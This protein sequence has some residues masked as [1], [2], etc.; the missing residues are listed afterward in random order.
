MAKYLISFPADAMQLTPGELRQ[1]SIDSHAVVAEA[2]PGSFNC[3]GRI[4]AIWRHLSECVIRSKYP[5]GIPR[6]SS[7]EMRSPSRPP[8]QPLN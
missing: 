3:A 5:P 1:A 2:K 4:E 6:D 7:S 8:T